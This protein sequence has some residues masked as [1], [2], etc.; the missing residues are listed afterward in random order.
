M[1]K[2]SEKVHFRDEET[3][4]L[5]KSTNENKKRKP[6]EDNSSIN[7]DIDDLQR[8]INK[9]EDVPTQYGSAEGDLLGTS[10]RRSIST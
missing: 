9:A 6:N 1:K 2:Q 4:D 7:H 8:Q 5:I 3:V 10:T